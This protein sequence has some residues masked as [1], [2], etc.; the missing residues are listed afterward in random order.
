MI[1]ALIAGFILMRKVIGLRAL[2]DVEGTLSRELK[3]MFQRL[4]DSSGNGSVA[5]A[6]E[7]CQEA[8]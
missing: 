4:I 1:L 5:A 6:T 7:P 8:R 3:M 2:S